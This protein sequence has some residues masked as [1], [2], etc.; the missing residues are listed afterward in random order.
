MYRFFTKI[1]RHI[2]ESPRWED[3]NV[4]S[5]KNFGA[6]FTF[7]KYQKII[8][9]QCFLIFFMC[10]I[11]FK[12]FF[13]VCVWSR[14]DLTH[15]SNRQIFGGF[16]H[17]SWFIL[18]YYFVFCFFCLSPFQERA[19]RWW[20]PTTFLPS[21]LEEVVIDAACGATGMHRCQ[22]AHILVVPSGG[23]KSNCSPCGRR[24]ERTFT[25]GSFL[26]SPTREVLGIKTSQYQS[27]VKVHRCLKAHTFTPYKQPILLR[28]LF[29]FFYEQHVS[30]FLY[31][32]VVRRI[33]I[34]RIGRWCVCAYGAPH[35]M[36]E[37][38]K[39]APKPG[40]EGCGGF[41][42]PTPW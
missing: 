9:L 4:T 26:F 27:G 40:G 18:L 38:S 31:S 28:G 17:I 11:F 2:F 8:F 5:R 12:F 36:L 33:I 15:A 23:T 19:G 3:S 22:K 16:C 6:F 13:Y 35:K 20:T 24:A 42:S 39:P 7:P 34:P 1:L 30:L 10:W 14:W 37:S 21:P 29:L 32:F 25:K 41:D